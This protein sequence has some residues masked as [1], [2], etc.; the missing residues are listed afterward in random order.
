MTW[1]IIK[2]HD[3]KNHD[4][5]HSLSMGE[6]LD[7]LHLILEN[8]VKIYNEVL[9]TVDDDGH[10]Q[11]NSFE[12]ASNICS[13]SINGGIQITI[14]EEPEKNMLRDRSDW[15]GETSEQENRQ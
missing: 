10:K 14:K 13:L 12:D 9:N 7:L 15:H 5:Y 3:E 2:L 4:F 11:I 8:D 1:E 6:K